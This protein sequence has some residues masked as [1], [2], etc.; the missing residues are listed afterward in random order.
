MSSPSKQTLEPPL[1]GG[2]PGEIRRV[3]GHAVHVL[4]TCG[5]PG[6]ETDPKKSD[7][8]AVTA[9]ELKT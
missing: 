3:Q 1:A 6:A 9:G 5:N 2:R 7:H 8:R 4:W